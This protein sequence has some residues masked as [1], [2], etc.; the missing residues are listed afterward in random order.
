MSEESSNRP[1]FDEGYF[2]GGGGALDNANRT[3]AVNN[4]PR[5]AP[6]Q[7]PM[8]RA[9]YHTDD[10]DV[11]SRFR[12]SVN[13]R[14]SDDGAA[15]AVDPPVC[16]SDNNSAT[17]DSKTATAAA[18]ADTTEAAIVQD[19]SMR[20]WRQAPL[21]GPRE[22]FR[23]NTHST[24][25]RGILQQ[26]GATPAK[27]SA[28][29]AQHQQQQGKKAA[30]P[31]TTTTAT[32]AAA[33]VAPELATRRSPAATAYMEQRDGLVAESPKG[34]PRPAA[35]SRQRR[36]SA[37]ATSP[38]LTGLGG[39]ESS[40]NDHRPAV[41]NGR[42]HSHVRSVIA[43]YKAGNLSYLEARYGTPTGGG[44]GGESPQTPQKRAA[45]VPPSTTTR[46]AI[47]RGPNYREVVWTAPAVPGRS[48]SP[49]PRQPRSGRAAPTPTGAFKQQHQQQQQ[50]GEDRPHPPQQ[51]H[52]TISATRYSYRQLS[53]RGAKPA[54]LPDAAPRCA[55]LVPDRH[56]FRSKEER[57][58]DEAAARHARVLA[59]EAK[60]AAEAAAK[61]EGVHSGA[62][63]GD[64]TNAIVVTPAWGFDATPTPGGSWG[65]RSSSNSSR[66]RGVSPRGR[67][68][69]S[70]G[71]SVNKARPRGASSSSASAGGGGASRQPNPYAHR[72]M[73]VFPIQAPVLTASA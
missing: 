2:G 51:H 13:S 20:Q 47:S 56:R 37:A 66:R 16:S 29:P 68:A 46:T 23:R 26:Q 25:D 4:A 36:P 14:Y 30:S 65:R 17:A 52:L 24:G 70:R 3:S 64:D 62:R 8:P 61:A 5:P 21:A 19:L 73:L 41:N 45:Y 59:A 63:D 40:S 67:S 12:P 71:R 60:A 49:A 50:G 38:R 11:D 35:V 31:A 53:P 42:R 57:E 44:G 22:E 9:S 7:A 48:V 32:P 72:K 69:K 10:D 6:A 58:A 43:D 28:P 27:A 55:S 18:Y 34:R 15:A 39:D 54:T 33:R 1:S